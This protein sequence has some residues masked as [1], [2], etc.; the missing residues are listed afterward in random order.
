MWPAALPDC[1][2]ANRSLS[3][4]PGCVCSRIPVSAVVYEDFYRDC[5]PYAPNPGKAPGR[6]F[7]NQRC[8]LFH[9][10]YQVQIRFGSRFPALRPR[11]VEESWAGPDDTDNSAIIGHAH[12]SNSRI[13]NH[14]L[15]IFL[16]K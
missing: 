8:H 16:R 15:N 3:A 2:F 10:F 5:H 9:L 13:I 11:K 6:S 12:R 14:E 1:P 7:Q 4:S